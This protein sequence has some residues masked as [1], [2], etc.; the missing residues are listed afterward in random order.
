[1]FQSANHD[2]AI[3]FLPRFR[4]IFWNKRF[5]V[6]IDLIANG[7][8]A[9]LG[10]R[11]AVH[12]QTAHHKTVRL[13]RAERRRRSLW[14]IDEFTVEIGRLWCD[15]Q[16]FNRIQHRDWQKREANPNWFP[17]IDFH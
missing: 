13:G 12:N 3:T 8:T 14:P 16:R 6:F 15:P 17:T 1:M 7:E 4:Q 2:I 10:R 5:D 9:R 11:P